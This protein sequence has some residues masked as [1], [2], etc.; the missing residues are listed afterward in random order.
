[1]IDAAHSTAMQN[2]VK[3]SIARQFDSNNVELDFY[4]LFTCIKYFKNKELKSLFSIFTA[5]DSSKILNIPEKDYQWLIEEELHNILDQHISSHSFSDGKNIE[6]VIYILALVELNKAQTALV[7]KEFSKLISS[8]KNTINT[9]ESINSFLFFQHHLFKNKINPDILFELIEN[10]IKK[11]I[12]HKANGW[13][14]HAITG[15]RVNNLYGLVEVNDVCFKNEKLITILLAELQELPIKD[16][17]TYARSLLFSI[18]NIGNKKIKVA[19]ETF[20]TETISTTDYDDLNCNF[21]LWIIAVDFKEYNEEV[22]T[23]L[24]GY[25]D[26]YREEKSFSSEFYEIKRLV[27]YL[28]TE[29][30]LN[31]FEESQKILNDLILKY[32]SR[33]NKSFI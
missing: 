27:D 11:I 22:I 21:S 29:K 28:I 10:I 23:K 13:D 14:I 19:I 3:I 24:K 20:I 32:E 33:D 5:K 2:F 30:Q 7:M 31:Q 12:H 1:M 4:E 26:K 16:K 6:N 25:L 8:N 9:Y 18:F 15:G 17:I